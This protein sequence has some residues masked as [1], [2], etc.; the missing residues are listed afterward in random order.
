MNQNDTAL[1]ND[2]DLDV[3]IANVRSQAYRHLAEG[4]RKPWQDDFDERKDAFVDSWKGLLDLLQEGERFKPIVDKIAQTLPNESFES[5]RDHYNQLFEP[6]GGLKAQPYETEYTKKTPA[7][8]LSHGFEMADIAGFYKAFGLEVSDDVPERVD[9]ITMQLEFM[10]VLASK[11]AV[12]GE[13]AEQEHID[14]VRDAQTKFLKEHLGIWTKDFSE[15]ITQSN[16]GGFY[17]ALGELLHQ[18]VEFDKEFVFS[19]EE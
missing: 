15:R 14:L 19:D 1:D 5:L 9:H 2:I 7:H 4:F 6:H 3:V 12:A 13:K 16:I 8:A 11:E 17:A 10:H 18:W